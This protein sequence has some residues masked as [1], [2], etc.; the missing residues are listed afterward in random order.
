MSSDFEK[1]TRNDSQDVGNQS[2]YYRGQMYQRDANAVRGPTSG[3]HSSG[4]IVA[5]SGQGMVITGEN[6]ILQA[7]VSIPFLIIGLALYPV[8]AAATI[9]AGLLCVRLTPMFGAGA[10]WERWLAYLPMLVVFWVV[11]RWDVR[12]AVRNTTYRRVRHG[13]RLLVFAFIGYAIAGYFASSGRV[14]AL[15]T[16]PK[17]AGLFVGAALGHWFLERGDGWRDFWYRTLTT[18]R[19][20]PAN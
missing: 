18:F 19:L 17:V 11:M 16:L 7:I 10:T 2:E 15:F 1:G 20:K 14:D 9:L 3:S 4:F 8:T 13:A 6:P 12:M 5:P